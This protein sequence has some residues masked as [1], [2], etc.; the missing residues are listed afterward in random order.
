MKEEVITRAT[1]ERYPNFKVEVWVSS[2]LVI[3]QGHFI[4][5]HPLCCAR[6]A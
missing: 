3:S 6:P 2:L 1:K 5:R 4:G